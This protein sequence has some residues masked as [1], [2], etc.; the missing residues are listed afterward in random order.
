MEKSVS[1]PSETPQ[2]AP[3]KTLSKAKRVRL[4]R[5][6]IAVLTVILFILIL[7]ML[8]TS[9]KP[10]SDQSDIDRLNSASSAFSEDAKADNSQDE[11]AS[12][13]YLS[14]FLDILEDNLQARLETLG[15]P[16]EEFENLGEYL[17]KDELYEIETKS[18]LA[19]ALDASWVEAT[20]KSLARL[21]SIF[22]L[23][24]NRGFESYEHSATPPAEYLR[25]DD[26]LDTYDRTLS[27]VED[28]DIAE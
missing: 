25:L 12:Y 10:K 28:Y 22:E 15:V 16:E 6:I 21:K 5:V 2:D 8:P 17:S 26:L 27:T 24:A 18:T 1:N 9:P 13:Y 7:D 14:G 23:P 3:K 19:E 20:P 11:T 4:A